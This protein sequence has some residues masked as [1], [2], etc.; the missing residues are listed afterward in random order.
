[1]FLP[2]DKKSKVSFARI[3]RRF[4][5]DSFAQRKFFSG[6]DKQERTG[7]SMVLQREKKQTVFF[8][9][10]CG[11]PEIMLI[12]FPERFASEHFLYQ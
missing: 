10:S 9:E 4:E 11:Q 1:M 12:H 7:V 6:E 3:V 5:S 2:E 8:E